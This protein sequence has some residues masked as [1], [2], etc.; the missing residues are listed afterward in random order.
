M[1]LLLGAQLM[2]PFSEKCISQQ[3]LGR[4]LPHYPLLCLRDTVFPCLL[5]PRALAIY[6]K[7]NLM[8]R[9][10]SHSTSFS[11]GARGKGAQPL[12]TSSPWTP[13]TSLGT[14]TT[15]WAKSGRQS[16]DSVRHRWQMTG[17]LGGGEERDD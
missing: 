8:G 17:C 16:P 13:Q 1:N 7:W 12:I 6:R 11:L 2:T 15:L 5:E 4:S 3:A 9:S 14:G 10:H